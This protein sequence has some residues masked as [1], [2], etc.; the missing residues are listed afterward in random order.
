MES[1]RN[2]YFDEF[3]DRDLMTSFQDVVVFKN[4]L[5]CYILGG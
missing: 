1:A 3:F 5:S 4:V 2:A